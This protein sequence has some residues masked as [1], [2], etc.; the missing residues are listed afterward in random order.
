MNKASRMM[1]FIWDLI[2]QKTKW[3]AN[4]TFKE[5]ELTVTLINGKRGRQFRCIDENVLKSEIKEFVQC[6]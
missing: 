6:V 2:G 4:I 1:N 5:N 3:S